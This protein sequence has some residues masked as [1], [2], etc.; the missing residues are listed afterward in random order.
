MITSYKYI[1]FYLSTSTANANTAVATS[2]FNYI[3]YESKC[4]SIKY[5]Q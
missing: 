3:Q 5:M 2:I 4:G 1:S